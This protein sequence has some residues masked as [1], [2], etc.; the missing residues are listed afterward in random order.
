M[1]VS[2]LFSSN[3]RCLFSDKRLCKNIQ[4]IENKLNVFECIQKTSLQVNIRNLFFFKKLYSE[5]LIEYKNG[6]EMNTRKLIIHE[7]AVIR[8][9]DTSLTK[10]KQQI[11]GKLLP[12][13]LDSKNY[14][15]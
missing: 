2:L 15:D 3:E 11:G 8:N 5:I 14:H 10:K 1:H 4:V 6:Y 9:R 7:A 12:V 13:N